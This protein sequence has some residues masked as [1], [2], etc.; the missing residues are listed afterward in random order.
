M[1]EIISDGGQHS[2]LNGNWLINAQAYCVLHS[3]AVSEPSWQTCTDRT[4]TRCEDICHHNGYQTYLRG[5]KWPQRGGEHPTHLAMKLRVIKGI[6]RVIALCVCMSCY[7]ET[8]TLTFKI[9]YVLYLADYLTAFYEIPK[10]YKTGNNKWLYNRGWWSTTRRNGVG[11]I[12]TQAR[13]DVWEACVNSGDVSDLDSC[14]MSPVARF[15][16]SVATWMRTA[17]FWVITVH[18]VVTL[19][20]R[21]RITYRYHFQER[22]LKVGPTGC[23]RNVGIWNYRHMHPNSPEERSSPVVR[24]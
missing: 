16:A 14:D 5:V 15:Q 9:C 19:Y 4:D 6:I 1:C 22:L 11:N 18:V 2:W 12:L 20:R 21:F 24:W 23:P 10:L 7:G 3:T 13:F 8:F 17:P